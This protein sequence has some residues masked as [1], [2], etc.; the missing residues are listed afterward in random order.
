MAREI[1]IRKANARELSKRLESR[2]WYLLIEGTER[3]YPYTLQEKYQLA[4]EVLRKLE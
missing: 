1:S 3:N 2:I 4:L